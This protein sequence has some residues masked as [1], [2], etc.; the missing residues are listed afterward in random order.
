MTE[1]AVCEFVR[2]DRR[3]FVVVRREVQHAF[4]QLYV[5]PV[6]LGARQS[7]ANDLETRPAAQGGGQDNGLAI[8]ERQGDLSTPETVL[9]RRLRPADVGVGIGR[10]RQDGFAIHRLYRTPRKTWRLA[11]GS[12]DCR[13]I[14]QTQYGLGVITHR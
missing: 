1:Y 8:V 9:D 4:R 6:G 11:N 14:P 12:Q 7:A 10:T 3:Q 13:T 5:S 2:E